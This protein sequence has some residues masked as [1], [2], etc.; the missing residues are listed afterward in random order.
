M[1]IATIEVL[2]IELF[3]VDKNQLSILFLFLIPLKKSDDDSTHSIDFRKVKFMVLLSNANKSY[4]KIT[5]KT[6]FTYSNIAIF[7]PITRHIARKQ[8]RSLHSLLR[9]SILI[10]FDE[11]KKLPSVP[12]QSQLIRRKTGGAK[13]NEGKL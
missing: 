10:V 13:S 9:L 3:S 12:E 5:N 4:L 6:Y 2:Y 11:L 7:S 1:L 8:L